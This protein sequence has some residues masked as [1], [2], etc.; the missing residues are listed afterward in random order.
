[1]IKYKS[2]TITGKITD[3]EQLMF[4][5]KD[6]FKKFKKDGAGKEI[7]FHIEIL[8]R[9]GSTAL[10]GYWFAV[11]VPEIQSALYEKGDPMKQDDCE[12]F[13]REM[14]PLMWEEEADHLTGKYTAELKTVPSLNH[15]ELVEFVEFIRRWALADLQ[16]Y[17]RD[18]LTFTK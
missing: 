12:R 6:H 8:E 16:M 3:K 9:P 13:L 14:C 1:M 18:P 17:V 5:E 7:A 10:R 11:I 2:K 15:P 4:H